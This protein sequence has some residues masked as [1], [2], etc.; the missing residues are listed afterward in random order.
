MLRKTIFWL[1]LTIGLGIAVIVLIMSVTGVLLTY[2]RQMQSWADMRGLNGAPPTQD[3]T[4]LPTPVL[5]EKA[6]TAKAAR[7]SAI[8]W[9]AA[10]DAPVEV[11]FGREGSLFLNAYTGT[12]LGSGSAGMHKFFRVV[13]D[14]HR[15]L[16]LQGGARERGR[17]ITSAANLGFLFLVLGGFYLWWP[18]NWTGAAFRNVL[19]F[20]RGL[21]SKAR[22]FNWHNVIGIWS[23]VPLVIIVFSGVVISY[24]WAGRLVDRIA[25]TERPAAA[26]S[27]TASARAGAD[28]RADI[29][30][31]V[32]R[33]KQQDREWRQISLDLA[34][35]KN[36]NQTF[37]I[38][39]S[40]GGQPHKRA[41]LVLTPAGDVARWQPLSAESRA[42]QARSILRFAHTGE[43]GGIVGQTLAGLV[44]AGVLVLVYT[45][46]A[47]ALR[48]FTAWRNRRDRPGAIA[49]TQPA[50]VG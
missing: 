42:R 49:P 29:D 41:Q 23:W 20:R 19:L 12:A 10:Q 25:G 44:S 45:G 21:P 47:L 43:I 4:P 46:V 28:G 24:P 33:A 11:V 40:N 6:R 31:L 2:Q 8:R 39:R 38:D 16:G 37:T 32:A 18:R 15:W 22:D 27:A 17:M 30:A 26:R 36:G 48:R 5:L 35:A 50:S 9:R 7:P 3:A 14:W 1:H 34:P 13:T